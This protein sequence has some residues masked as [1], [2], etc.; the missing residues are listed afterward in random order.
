MLWSIW[1]EA[2]HQMRIAVLAEL[3][4]EAVIKQYDRAEG[5]SVFA[6][7]AAGWVS[8]RWIRSTWAEAKLLSLPTER[9]LGAQSS[10]L[11]NLLFSSNLKSL[12]G[13]LKQCT[14]L[15]PKHEMLALWYDGIFCLRLSVLARCSQQDGCWP[16]ESKF[17]ISA[18][19]RDLS[20][21][22]VPTGTYTYVHWALRIH[23]GVLR[24]V[25][26]SWVVPRLRTE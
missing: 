5:W 3:V 21:P 19:R 15:H 9:A 22:H 7:L 1:N 11:L 17:L 8:G 12:P 6:F 16:F 26:S 13:K 14:T 4:W 24:H 18:E 25:K 2:H 10:I 20:S 23:T